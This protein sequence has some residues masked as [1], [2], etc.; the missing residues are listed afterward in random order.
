MMT[1]VTDDPTLVGKKVQLFAK[2]FPPCET[3]QQPFANHTDAHAYV[4]NGPIREH[5]VI[6]EAIAESQA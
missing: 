4:P 2:V 6:A 1:F 5:G 3:C